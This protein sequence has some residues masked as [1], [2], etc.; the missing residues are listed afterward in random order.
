[1]FLVFFFF[2]EI[3][4]HQNEVSDKTFSAYFIAVHL[5]VYIY[6][7]ITLGSQLYSEAFY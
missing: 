4:G 1:M 5:F 2:F 3:L 7:S 6:I